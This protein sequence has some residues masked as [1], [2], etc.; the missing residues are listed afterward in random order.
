MDGRLNSNTNVV[1]QN[2]LAPIQVTQTGYNPVATTAVTLSAN[3]PATP[4][5]NTATAASPLSSDITVYD[6]LGTSHVVTL[7]WAQA[8]DG[9][10][11]VVPNS[12]TVKITA[13][14]ASFLAGPPTRTATDLGTADVTF[15]GAQ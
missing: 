9:N 13:G 11:N 10:G 6:S 14:R 12:W 7:N 1:N 3:L 8:Q 4:A 15:A 5:A 2:A